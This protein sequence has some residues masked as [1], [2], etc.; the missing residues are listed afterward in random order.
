LAAVAPQVRI[1]MASRAAPVLGLW[2]ALFR[3]RPDLIHAHHERS[4]RIAS[5]YALKIPVLATVHVHFRPRDFM[6]CESLV[7]LTTAEAQRIPPEYNGARFVIG[8]W[9][10]PH[11]PPSDA[12]R[13]RLRAEL[14]LTRADYLVGSVARLEPVKGMA[15]LIKAFAAANLPQSRLVIAGEGSERPALERLAKQ[16]NLGDRVV[17]AGFRPDIR[18]LYSLFDLFVLNSLDEPYGLA[19]LEAAA[20]GVKVIATRT[21]G[22]AAIAEKLP[23]SLIQVDSETALVSALRDAWSQ[24]GRP[25]SNTIA[26]FAIEDRLPDL[27]AAY[28]R[29]GAHAGMRNDD[30]HGIPAAAET[31]LVDH[32]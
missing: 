10:S 16:L 17:F 18:D 30:R 14:G 2:N 5:R 32:A 12:T 9:V 19:I 20:A 22:A 8:N 4:A 11:D 7:C 1:F 15:G 31:D 25:A 23:V 3:F 13:S 21:M 28:A 24:R 26:G 27:L 6:R 29:I